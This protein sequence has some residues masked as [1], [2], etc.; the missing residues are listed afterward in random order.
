M[1]FDLDSLDFFGGNVAAKAAYRA[2]KVNEYVAKAASVWAFA[3]GAEVATDGPVAGAD[4][5]AGFCFPVSGPVANAVDVDA[6]EA[7]NAEAFAAAVEAAGLEEDDF[8]GASSGI[9][10][11]E[12]VGD[13]CYV[14]PGAGNADAWG[15]WA[16][17]G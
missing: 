17:K 13:G 8:F 16:F 3:N 10:V 12:A 9:D 4:T 11:L 14:G 15:D 1:A 5:W 2:H 6:V 7:A